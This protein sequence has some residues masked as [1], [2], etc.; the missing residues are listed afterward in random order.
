[1]LVCVYFSGS[2]QTP[3]GRLLAFE[4]SDRED[5]AAPGSSAC[6]ME[7]GQHNN[8]PITKCVDQQQ[9][10]QSFKYQP[11]PCPSVCHA[12]HHLCIWKQQDLCVFL[13][14]TVRKTLGFSC[15]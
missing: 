4:M 7:A 9:D 3:G 11:A 13:A 2:Y 10:C 15:S 14:S 12:V 8:S 5:G 1:M 6:H